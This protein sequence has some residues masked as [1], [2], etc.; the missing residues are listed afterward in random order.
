MKVEQYIALNQFHLY[1]EGNHCLQ[2]YDSLVVKIQGNEVTLGRD[3]DY[4]KTTSKYV[5]QFLDDY[6]D[7]RIYDIPNKRDYIRKLI[8]EGTIK[9]DENM[10]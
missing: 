5:Y 9:Y 8:E 4:S 6:S 7:I 3:W 10:V 2:S 1:G